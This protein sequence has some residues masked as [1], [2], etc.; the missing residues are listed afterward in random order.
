MTLFANIQLAPHA[1]AI[2]KHRERE[3]KKR[4]TQA[5]AANIS[6]L[7]ACHIVTKQNEAKQQNRKITKWKIIACEIATLPYLC[8][9]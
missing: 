5:F 2:T 4:K 6:A 3:V 8:C 1:F 7:N 9:T